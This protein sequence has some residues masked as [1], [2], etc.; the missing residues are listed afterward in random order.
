MTEP[1][2]AP[3]D[4]DA[5]RADLA[6]VP[7]PP[8]RWKVDGHTVLVAGRTVVIATDHEPDPDGC[9]VEVLFHE[10]RDGR[11][12]FS[13][14][15]LVDEAGGIDN[16]V[17]RFTERAPD[18][19]A[20][21]LAALA[22]RD[23]TIARYDTA[24]IEVTRDADEDDDGEPTR[25]ALIET[26]AATDAERD[27]LE[28]VVAEQAAEIQR[29]R[30][31]AVAIGPGL[32]ALT[33]DLAG[34]MA[35]EIGRRDEADANPG[36]GMP[37]RGD[38]RLARDRTWAAEHAAERLEAERD[39]ARDDAARLRS[40]WRSAWRGRHELRVEHRDA[41]AV[42]RWALAETYAHRGAL[43]WM[44]VTD[45][46]PAAEPPLY[47]PRVEW[48]VQA[49]EPWQPGAAADGWVDDWGPYAR[50]EDAHARA[51]RRRA[52][53]GASEVRVLRVESTHWLDAPRAPESPAGAPA[54]KE[55]PDTR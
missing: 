47:P 10:V 26:I 21:L 41:V 34:R 50:R 37:T 22:E 52:R 1:T 51:A 8:W 44:R 28:A 38:W 53:P 25:E 17:A 42:A 54:S 31:T 48:V 14:T 6:A 20:A 12:M 13:G 7:A 39:E 24:L 27:R 3:L 11:S 9:D 46:S 29:L 32:G 19:V 49:R 33:A 2:A 55:T 4:L 18:Y 30:T 16:A 45:R 15:E 43:G 5:I 40:A 23:A 36:R 35:A